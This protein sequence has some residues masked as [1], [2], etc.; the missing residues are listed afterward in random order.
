MKHRPV[1]ILALLL[2]VLGSGAALAPSGYDLSWWTAAGGGGSSESV[3][4]SLTGA[5]GQSAA[6]EL[7]GTGYQLSGGFWAGGSG[8]PIAE[9]HKLYLPLV[10]R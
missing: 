9:Q 3:S 1:F 2:V 8:A 5:A 6:G 10:T 4:Y 7:R